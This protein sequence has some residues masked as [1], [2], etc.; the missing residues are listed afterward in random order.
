MSAGGF[1]S[2]LP[3]SFANSKWPAGISQ[4]SK[5]VYKAS[6][7]TS[8]QINALGEIHVIALDVPHVG[9]PATIM[10][11]TLPIIEHLPFSSRIYFFYISESVVDDQVTFVPVAGS[12]NTVNGDLFSYTFTLTGFPQLLIGMAVNGNY[13]IHNFGANEPSSIP[14]P[15]LPALINLP[16]MQFLDCFYA[17]PGIN[18]IALT[19]K[20]NSGVGLQFE[21]PS[22]NVGPPIEIIPGMT[23]FV[24]QRMPI[25]GTPFYGFRVNVDGYYDVEIH[26]RIQVIWNVPS[27]PVDCHPL[28]LRMIEYDEF[29]SV[30]GYEH[31]F[32]TSGDKFLGTVFGGNGNGFTAVISSSIL[33]LF[34]ATCYYA[35][36]LVYD[37][38]DNGP[39]LNTPSSA[40]GAL[41]QYYMNAAGSW[42]TWQ[43]YQYTPPSPPPPLMLMS[44]SKSMMTPS[45]S[46]S[47]NFDWVDIVRK[48]GIEVDETSL[49]LLERQQNYHQRLQM[50]WLETEK[51]KEKKEEPPSILSL[52]SKTERS[53]RQLEKIQQARQ[54]VEMEDR[55]RLSSASSS[56]AAPPPISLK[57]IEDIYKRLLQDSQRQYAV[58]ASSSSSS[59]AAASSS[60]PI[61]RP[62][63]PLPS[64]PPPSLEKPPLPSGPAPPAS[65]R[66]RVV[67]EKEKA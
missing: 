7:Q 22:I 19:K 28:Y 6:V 13:I 44:K 49:K 59:S 42:V 30:T 45:S 53:K 17:Y 50:K 8:W 60:V 56:S 20:T 33:S 32:S 10:T 11:L 27:I 35:F 31:L 21:G 41:T 1:T 39:P 66:K 29:G 63:P 40:T 51:T 38:G 55:R 54:D 18:P 34:W 16:T 2:F 48:N 9:P 65:K 24:D 14:P 47:L 36:E 23:G 64:L 37:A 67:E 43:Y 61:Q 26:W 12:G 62:S 57:D 3:E 25:P 58:A 4:D 5:S 15:A 46:P 52:P